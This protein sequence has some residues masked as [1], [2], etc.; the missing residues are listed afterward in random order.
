MRACMRTLSR[1]SHKV[2]ARESAS[3]R[4]ARRKKRGRGGRKGSRG[5][6]VSEALK[7]IRTAEGTPVKYISESDSPSPKKKVSERSAVELSEMAPKTVVSCGDMKWGLRHAD[8]S[9]KRGDGGTAIYQLKS[10]TLFS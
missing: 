10:A 8:L 4:R 2:K 7:G 5:K 3:E 9:S 1:A 6:E